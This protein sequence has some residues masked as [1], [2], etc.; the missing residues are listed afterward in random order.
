M[1]NA[2][3]G[4]RGSIVDMGFT[5]KPR[6]MWKDTS[7]FYDLLARSQSF[8]KDGGV[9]TVDADHKLVSSDFPTRTDM[10]FLPLGW[11]LR[12]GVFLKR[13]MLPDLPTPIVYL[14]R[15][16]GKGWQH[17]LLGLL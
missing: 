5:G 6:Y 9:I 11:S 10:P 3:Y 8:P 14:P 16:Y 12:A 17:P 1:S 7:D 13:R 15:W 2:L 4:V